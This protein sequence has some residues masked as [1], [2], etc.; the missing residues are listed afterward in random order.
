MRWS[1]GGGNRESRIERDRM[2]K[3]FFKAEMPMSGYGGMR[4]YGAGSGKRGSGDSREE[5]GEIVE[6][7]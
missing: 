7:G 1:E 3:I 5:D 2:K 4:D 6:E